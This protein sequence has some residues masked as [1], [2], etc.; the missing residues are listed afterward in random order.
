MGSGPSPPTMSAIAALRATFPNAGE[1]GVK[2][3]TDEA[4]RRART[5]D[6]NMVTK[7][8]QFLVVDVLAAGSFYL[9]YRTM[10]TCAS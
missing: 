10:D 2:A 1:L 8:L 9:L 4:A 3:A 7:F 6:L 5:E